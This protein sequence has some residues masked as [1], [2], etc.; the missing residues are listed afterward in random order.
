M[1]CLEKQSCWIF[2]RFFFITNGVAKEKK[3]YHFTSFH[4]S[5]C[6]PEIT[7]SA[8]KPSNRWSF[9]RKEKYTKRR[10]TYVL[11]KEDFGR[12][13]LK[14]ESKNVDCTGIKKYNNMLVKTEVLLSVP[15]MGIY[16]DI[17]LKFLWSTVNSTLAMLRF[18]ILT[19]LSR[20]RRWVKT[21][22]F[23]SSNPEWKLHWFQS[24]INS[25]KL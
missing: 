6:Q 23:K 3:T 1:F 25:I 14:I 2:L 11:R 20:Q 12:E 4:T 22:G 5:P 15:Q 9:A 24:E 16:R 18:N 8:W 10:K 21:V 17:S 7:T 13:W 19:L